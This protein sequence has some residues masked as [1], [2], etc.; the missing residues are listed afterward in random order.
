M[1]K[2]KIKAFIKKAFTPI[3][4]VFIPYSNVKSR[5]IHIPSIGILTII[6]IWAAF[7]YIALSS[8]VG[9]VEY[10]RMKSKLNYYA[11]QFTELNN[12]IGTLKQAES[13]LLTLLSKGS[14]EAV[15][16]SVDT[17]DRGSLEDIEAIRKEAMER[18]K[19]VEEIKEY[20]RLQR[21]IFM[22]TPR[23]WPVDGRVTSH[24]GRR[25]HPTDGFIDFHAA[26]DIASPPG[27]Q[28][29][30]TAD[31]IASYSGRS[32]GNGNVV[33]IEHGH[34][35]STLYAHNKENLVKVGQQVK[36][37]DVIAKLGS[38]GNSTGPHVHYEVWKNGRHVN[39]MPYI[40][41]RDESSE[42][43]EK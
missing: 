22:A 8:A 38:T 9:R 35:F 17:S 32:G 5:S 30:A 25:E 2:D 43:K 10:Q 15:L 39:P 29:K 4:I 33:V 24:Y 3:T 13:D 11:E 42:R 12:T 20:L 1:F 36:R 19:S 26:V 37:G 27:S 16:M 34:G 23:G 7:S 21:D 18:V 6:A 28:I 31:G 40:S 41:A 14:K